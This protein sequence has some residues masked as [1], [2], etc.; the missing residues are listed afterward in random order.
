MNL[1][2]PADLY[3]RQVLILGLG[4][5]GGGAGC[6]RALHELGAKVTVSDLRPASKLEESV[7]S[8]AGYPIEFV[9]EEHPE[10]LFEQADVIVVNPAVP[11][12]SPIWNLA[13]KHSCE[14]TT[15]VNLAIA[16]SAHIKTV[17]ITGT[18]GKSTCASILHHLLGENTLLAG[19]LGGS[20]LEQVMSK[21]DLET[22]VVEMSSFQCERLVAPSGWPHI[23]ILTCFGADHLDRHGDLAAYAVAKRRL[24]EYQDEKC[25]T[26][27]SGNDDESQ[28]WT[29]AAHGNWMELSN[30]NIESFGLTIDDLPFHEEFRFPSMFAAL[31]AQRILKS[32]GAKLSNWPG[33]E[34]RMQSFTDIYQRKIVNNGVATHPDP[35]AAAL[36]SISGKKM[37][38]AGGHDKLLDLSEVIRA[39]R[40]KTRLHLHS[41]G[42]ARLAQLCSEAGISSVF[43]DSFREAAEAALSDLA[44]DETLLFSPTFASFDEFNNFSERAQLFL[45]LTEDTP[46][47][48]V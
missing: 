13:R 38:L 32:D 6:A 17:A 45:K 41:A 43:H 23:A 5:F 2:H 44:A 26:L 1:I 4:S 34:H 20:F 47:N 18:H 37:L 31:Q 14:L 29:R 36:D 24:L 7:N 39:V 21:P 33:L 40:K 42:G 15:E 25:F 28:H 35:T 11:N 22:I 3:N 9:F 8:L 19:N 16:F 10:S 30:C 12:Q 48:R 27:V 46:T